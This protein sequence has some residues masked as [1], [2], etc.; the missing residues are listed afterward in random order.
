MKE[1]A[2]TTKPR[3]VPTLLSSD[4]ALVMGAIQVKGSDL[5]LLNEDQLADYE[6]ARTECNHWA[7]KLRMARE[8]RLDAEQRIEELE[9]EYQRIGAQ[10]ELQRLRYERVNTECLELFRTLESARKRRNSIA[11]DPK[12]AKLLTELLGVMR[13]L[14][15]IRQSLAEVYVFS[16]IVDG[17]TRT[18]RVEDAIDLEEAV[19]YFRLSLPDIDWVMVLSVVKGADTTIDDSE[20]APLFQVPIEELNETLGEMETRHFGRQLADRREAIV[21]DD[22]TEP[23]VD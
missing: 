1:G 5:E 3:P 11:K 22:F 23:I 7:H 8:D 4:T 2:T 13:Q 21:S 12:E 6:V 10:L 17:H 19:R 14:D 16:Y 20:W 18:L 9:Y 15:R